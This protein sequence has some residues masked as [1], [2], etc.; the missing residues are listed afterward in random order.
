[1]DK[2]TIRVSVLV[3][4]LALILGLAA[5]FVPNTASAA[6][7]GELK[8]QLNALKKQKSNLESQ[9]QNLKNQISENSSEI[10]KMVAEK[11]VID[12]EIFLLYQQIDNINHQI[13]T[14]SMLIADKQEELVRPDIRSCWKKTGSG[15][16]LWRK[17]ATCPTGLCCSRPMTSLIFWTG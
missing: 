5:G 12:Q 15:S 4:A 11:N 7:S 6:T 17:R 1:M 8:Q 14:Y 2:K 9:I 3:L 16:R 13:A 10:E